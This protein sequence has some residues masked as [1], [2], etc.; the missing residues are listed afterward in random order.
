LDLGVLGREKDTSSQV[1]M[2]LDKTANATHIRVDK[3]S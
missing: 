3:Q 2:S 1:A